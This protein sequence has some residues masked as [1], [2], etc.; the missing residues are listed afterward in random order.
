MDTEAI[1]EEI[2]T[3]IK[4][5]G[6]FDQYDDSETGSFSQGEYLMSLI[7]KLTRT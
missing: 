3:I 1:M 2:E 4:K 6:L 7:E 5:S